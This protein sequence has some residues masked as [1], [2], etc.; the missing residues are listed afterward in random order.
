MTCKSIYPVHR[1]R[2]IALS[3][4]STKIF[5]LSPHGPKQITCHP[6]RK[7]TQA[8]IFTK[9]GTIIPHNSI[10]FCR[11]IIPI[12]N[13]V[14]NL[15]LQLDNNLSW[16]HQVN[17]VIMRSYN[18]LRTFRRFAPVLSM[19]TRRKLVQSVIM[20]IFMYCDAVY[21][22]GITAN[23]KDRLHRCFKSTLRFVHGLRRRDST[24]TVRSSILGHDLPSNYRLRICCFMRQA[25]FDQLPNY[26]MEHMQHG[27]QERTRSF[28]V[29]RHTTSSGKSLLIH[30]ASCWNGV[31]H[32]AKMKPTLTSFKTALR[33][34]V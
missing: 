12:S 27:R 30:G 4:P 6:I 20:P 8:I 19:P 34:L 1:L 21:Y 28:I 18:I 17:E 5:K 16:N 13:K 9:A 2:S 11:E 15:G 14:T 10:V 3:T 7:K 22:P 24:Q 26:I 32:A 31:P 25:Y 33:R 23:L 29:P